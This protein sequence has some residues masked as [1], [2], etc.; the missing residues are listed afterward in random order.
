MKVIRNI[1]SAV[2]GYKY[3]SIAV[4]IA[5]FGFCM[6]NNYS[7]SK[8]ISQSREKVYVLNN[9]NS[10]E[11]ALARNPE[12]NREAEIKSHVT[13]FHQFFYNLDPDPVDIKESIE[14]ALYLIGESGKQMQFA[15]EENLYYSKIIDASISTRVKID[16][17]QLDMSRNPYLVNIFA[18]QK[19]IRPSKVLFKNLVSQCQVRNVKR[20]DNNP[21]G[22]II[23]KYNIL[24]NKTIKEIKR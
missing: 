21:H 2:K 23:E 8:L 6:F 22:L 9:G 19:L 3:V 13:M 17:I 7:T 1:D 12:E 16:S 15:R 20:T 14:R 11:M 10:L 18:R 24:D 4:I 5:A